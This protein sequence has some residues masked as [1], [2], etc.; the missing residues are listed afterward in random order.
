MNTK[1]KSNI[2]D[3]Y[4]KFGIYFKSENDISSNYLIELN[5]AKFKDNCLVKIY[6]TDILDNHFKTDGLINGDLIGIPEYEAE[7]IAEVHLYGKYFLPKFDNNL[8]LYYDGEKYY[9][10]DYKTNSITSLFEAINYAIEY[11]LY[12]NEITPY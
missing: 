9:N 7:W 8:Q 6:V 3:E 1:F 4:L 12:S 2:P 10:Y 5:E 11:G